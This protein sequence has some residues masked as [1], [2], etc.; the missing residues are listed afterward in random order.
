MLSTRGPFVAEV[1]QRRRHRHTEETGA[2]TVFRRLESGG[3]EA[4]ARLGRGSEVEGVVLG[5]LAEV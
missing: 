4:V 1:G 5:V 3:F 2:A